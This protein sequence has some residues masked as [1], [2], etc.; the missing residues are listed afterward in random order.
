MTY[1]ELKWQFKGAYEGGQFDSDIMKEKWEAYKHCAR[2]NKIV[3]W[4][5][6]DDF[7]YP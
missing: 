3:E 7:I 6:P 1:E 5:I 4:R 2:L